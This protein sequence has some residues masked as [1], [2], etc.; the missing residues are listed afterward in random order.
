MNREQYNDIVNGTQLATALGLI[1]LV[2]YDSQDRAELTDIYNRL[3]VYRNKITERVTTS[4]YP[5]PAQSSGE[6]QC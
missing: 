6:G 5:T 4:L 3:V 2:V 1:N